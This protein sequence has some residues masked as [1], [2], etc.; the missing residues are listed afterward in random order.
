MVHQHRRLIPAH[1]VLENIIR[2]HP[3]TKG[4]I[5]MKTPE[6]EVKKL[7]EKYGFKL[8]L[9]ARVWQLSVYFTFFYETNC[10]IPLF[11]LLWD[12]IYQQPKENK[13]NI[14]PNTV[15][16]ASKSCKL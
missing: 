10:K 4:I 1:T 9:N 16:E 13:K 3:E 8:D 2:G 14:L 12:Q 7:C 11:Y 15:K 5:D 6:V